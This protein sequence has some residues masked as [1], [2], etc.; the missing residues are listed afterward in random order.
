MGIS[1]S[2]DEFFES[3]A[4][5][6]HWVGAD[7]TILRANQAELDL[8]GYGR[9]EYVGRHIAEFHADP[10]T[11]VEILRRLRNGETLRDYPARLRRKD[12]TVK[13]VRITSN[14]NWQNQRFLHTRCFTRDVT[15]TV[16][17]LE[18]LL[19]GFVA[20]DADWVMTYMNAA[21]ERLLNR[22]R[23]DVLGR[24]WHQAFPH[25]V[26]NPVD[27]MYQRVMRTRQAERME[28]FYAH[29][30]RWLEISASAVRSGGVAVYFRDISDR[31]TLNRIGRTLT[32]ELD[33]ERVVQAVTDAATE[34]SGAQF[35]AF[36]YNVKNEA[37]ESYMLYSLSGVPR[38]A[39]AGFPMPRNTAV[40]EPTFSGRGSVCSDDITR[41]PRYGKSAPHHG[42]PKGHLPVKSYLAVPVISR[43]GEVLGGLFFGHSEPA[44]FGERAER[45]VAGIASQAAIAIDNARLYRSLQDSEQRYRAVVESQTELVCRF[46]PGGTILFVNGAYARAVGSTPENMIGRDFWTF[47]PPGE[48]AGVRE[49][50]HGLTPDAPEVRIENRFEATEGLR[51]MLWTNRALAFDAD[52]RVL[53]AQSTGVDITERRRAEEALREAD[54]RK[55]EFLA[56]LAHELRNPLAPIRNALHLMRVCRGAG[57]VA[58]EAQQVME[59][60]LAQLIRL[61]DDLLEVSRISRGKIELRRASVDLG[62]VVASAVETTRP[63]IDA[64]RHRLEVRLPPAPLRVEGDFVRLAQVIANLLNNAA[65]YTDPGGRIAVSVERDGGEAAIRVKDSGIGLAPELLPHIFDMFAQ[66]DRARA[67]GGLGI[68]L[69]LAKMLVDLHGGHIEAKSDGPGQGSEFAVR[70]PVGA[71]GYKE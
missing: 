2:L 53:E 38:E 49:L 40:F 7:G 41:D 12:G 20:Y 59:R 71:Q 18:G 43:S 56:M 9:D 48:H 24:T 25:A 37:G 66:A 35:G 44:V 33:L 60:Q 63:A 16:D 22:R 34:V 6:M 39:F 50:L 3:A 47:I 21:A 46:R 68:G 67:A 61:V 55:D 64:A 52:G 8:L 17:Y 54:R 15:Q 26:G 32:A 31:E 19:E 11:I 1:E 27:Q 51:W 28:Y 36:F 10:Q 42:M 4:M 57:P 45:L 65:K 5:P 29:Y 13:E 14:V 58:A 62:A 70:L 30:G 69:A 23:Y